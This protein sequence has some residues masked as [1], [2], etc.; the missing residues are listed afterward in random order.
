MKY[1]IVQTS[2]FKKDLR[3]AKKRGY[4]LALLAAVVDTLASGKPL[5]KYYKDHNL[6]GNYIRM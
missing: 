6:S 3:L 1:K 2:K 5:P 4:N